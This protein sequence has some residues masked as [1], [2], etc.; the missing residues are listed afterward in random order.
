[1]TT[2]T[3]TQTA[4]VVDTAEKQAVY[5]ATEGKV[6]DKKAQA[7]ADA[8]A[9]IT[10]ARGDTTIS[11][12]GTV[13]QGTD[14]TVV[15]NN[16]QLSTDDK[17]VKMVS[18]VTADTDLDRASETGQNQAIATVEAQYV[19]STT[20]ETVK[21]F[22]DRVITSLDIDGV[23]EQNKPQLLALL[24]EKVGERHSKLG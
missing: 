7:E 22:A 23:D 12:D 19:S 5:N 3:T 14:G 17:Q 4:D 9:A 8:Q 21:P 20:E 18:R 6:L 13:V 2:T 1:M 24:T 15:V 16:S 11:Q 10:A